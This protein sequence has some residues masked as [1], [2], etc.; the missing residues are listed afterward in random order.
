MGM[1]YARSHVFAQR[2]SNISESKVYVFNGSDKPKRFQLY[3]AISHIDNDQ[4]NRN[5]EIDMPK[6][7]RETNGHCAQ[8]SFQQQ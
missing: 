7:P 3:N 4:A 6:E 8:Q 5:N 1:S 2:F